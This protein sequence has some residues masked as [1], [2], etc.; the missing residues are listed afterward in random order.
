MERSGEESQ[1]PV[2]Y[3]YS[4]WRRHGLDRLYVK[5]SDGTD[6]GWYDLTRQEFNAVGPNGVFLEDAVAAWLRDNPVLASTSPPTRRDE[7][8]RDLAADAP[9]TRPQQQADRLRA[10]RME[11]LRKESRFWWF[12]RRHFVGTTTEE[13]SWRVGARGEMVVGQQLATLGPA[14]AVLHSIEVGNRGADID[15]LVIGPPGVFTINTKH[16]PR[17]SIFVDGDTF[18]VNGKHYP[19]VANSRFEA[20]RAANSL[21]RT[22]GFRVPV[23][24]LIVPLGFRKIVVRE[25]PRGVFVIA[26]SDIVPWLAGYPRIFPPH[27]IPT[28][29][30]QARISTTWLS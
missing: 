9:G 13:R 30:E 4:R 27:I 11:K 12:L 5:A 25:T 22:V 26:A 3:I 8:P 14:W 1:L 7:T 23:T 18:M 28:I 24:P 19:Y 15:H 29:H 21:S 17:G 16:H 20:K 2:R 6:F 10:E